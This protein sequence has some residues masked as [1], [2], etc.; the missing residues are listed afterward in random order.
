MSFIF[1][2]QYSFS[3]GE[4]KYSNHNSFINL[5]QIDPPTIP[6]PK[7]CLNMSVQN[8]DVNDK[9]LLSPCGLYCGTCSI[10][11]ATRVGDKVL[12]KIISEK[13]GTPLEK[14]ACL[15]CMQPEPVEVLYPHCNSCE[16]RACVKER[17]LS[18]C[19]QCDAFPCET[20]NSSVAK[21][22]A[23][24]LIPQWRDLCNELGEEE[25]G[26][27]F[28]QSQVEQFTCKNCGETLY[29]RATICN[30]CNAPVE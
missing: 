16:I 22:F 20:I 7:E 1:L 18:S 28:A 24:E 4:L 10:Y 12:Q 27:A 15:G 2:T 19:A 8:P 3:R 6:V 14:T 26:R 13:T 9:S 5:S 11:F 29:R 21:Q 30:Y 23:I 17:A 25:G